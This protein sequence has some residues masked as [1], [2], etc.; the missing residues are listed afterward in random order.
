MLLFCSL[1]HLFRQIL[2]C[3]VKEEVLVG[4]DTELT[5]LLDDTDFESDA[6]ETESWLAFREV[7]K[8]LLGNHKCP[9]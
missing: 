1:L 2:D 9:I 6:S 7:T 3:K 8:G 5:K 4:S